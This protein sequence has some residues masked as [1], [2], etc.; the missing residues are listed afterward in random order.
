[1]R[2]RRKH[3]NIDEKCSVADNENDDNH[4]VGHF[5]FPSHQSDELQSCQMS[6]GS[7][8]D[9]LAGSA[10]GRCFMHKTVGLAGKKLAKRKSPQGKLSQ[11]LLA[12]GPSDKMAM[13]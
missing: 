3:E 5:L 1:M 7:K 9:P 12:L 4:D 13:E 8:R 2:D 11:S 10:T 6:L